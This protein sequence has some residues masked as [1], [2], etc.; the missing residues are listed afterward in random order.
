MTR[1]GTTLLDRILGQLDGYF[2]IGEF[3][4]VWDHYVIANRLCG[5]GTK[6]KACDVWRD[7]FSNANI[8]FDKLVAE[9]MIRTKNTFLRTRHIPYLFLPG[10]HTRVTKHHQFFQ[11]NLEKLYRS[12]F[13][14]TSSR[15]IVDSSK[16]PTYA[17][18]LNMIP[19]IELY[20]VH[21]IRDPRAVAY[22]WQKVKT[23]VDGGM[24]DKR[25]IVNTSALW[26]IWNIS[27]DLFC[28]YNTM[29]CVRI[30]YEEFIRFPQESVQRI[31]N[32]TGEHVKTLPFT[33]DHEV[34]LGVT[35][36]VEGNPNRFQTGLIKLKMDDTWKREL[37]LHHRMLVNV[38]TWPLQK[39][40]N[41]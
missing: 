2:S 12:I 7:I 29:R 11:D 38:M 5:C 26:D 35:H 8:G 3:Y 16:Y 20:F 18:L 27:S 36:N 40:Y 1:S 19:S 39:R 32:L 41:Y 21:F 10:Y 31:I 24:M 33:S 30:K 4:A 25:G 9:K 34:K 37:K 17:S 15:V 22:S 14:T 13:A 28:Q 6:F 23:G